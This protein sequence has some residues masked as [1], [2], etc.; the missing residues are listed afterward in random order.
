MSTLGPRPFDGR[1]GF[2]LRKSDA[3]GLHRSLKCS[4]S[5]P[6]NARARLPALVRAETMTSQ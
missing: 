2:A 5:P 3:T 1:S 6:P 4:I